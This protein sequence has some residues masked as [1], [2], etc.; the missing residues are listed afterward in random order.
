MPNERGMWNAGAVAFMEMQGPDDSLG[1]KT[2]P[3]GMVLA[4]EPCT[5]PTFSNDQLLQ[6][7]Y[8]IQHAPSFYRLILCISHSMRQL[9][10]NSGSVV[11]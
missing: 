2:M 11:P 8:S 3:S 4:P 1:A 10:R 6:Q 5:F 7:K 9:L